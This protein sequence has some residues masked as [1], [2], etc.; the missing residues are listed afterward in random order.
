MV[1]EIFETR[2]I[3]Y[4][5]VDYD[6]DLVK[7]ERSAGRRVFYGDARKPEV[8]KSLGV[9]DAPL[10]VVTLD[11]FQAT[12]QA[13]SLLHRMYPKLDILARGHDKEHCKSLQTQGAWLTISEN[14]E[15]SI[16][17]AEAALSRIGIDDAENDAAI[18]RFRKDYYE[19]P[20]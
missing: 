16:A 3:T 6:A 8:L 14:L 17:L 7:R 2:N 12:Q 1:G 13:V 19:H 10:I 20:E 11:D 15:A 18:D 5:A 9:G 4:V